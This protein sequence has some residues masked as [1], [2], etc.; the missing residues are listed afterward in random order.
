MAGG[1]RGTE[2]GRCQVSIDVVGEGVAGSHIHGLRW[3]GV[4]VEG[5]GW[6]VSLSLQGM[7][8]ACGQKGLIPKPQ[9][10]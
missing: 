7:V 10:H 2:G 4:E 8:C 1:R 9:N 5:F 3:V 6:G